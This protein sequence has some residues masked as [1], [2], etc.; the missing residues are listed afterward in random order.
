MMFIIA[1]FCTMYNY[2][3]ISPGGCYDPN[4]GISTGENLYLVMAKLG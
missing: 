3:F 4:V 2:T 1:D